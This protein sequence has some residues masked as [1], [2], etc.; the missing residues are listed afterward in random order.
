MASC[1][2]QAAA[3]IACAMG[4]S[5]EPPPL[6]DQTDDVDNTGGGRELDW[7]D[8][9]DRRAGPADPLAQAA[10]AQPAR[11]AGLDRS[12]RRR[13]GTSR[14][15]SLGLVVNVVLRGG[16]GFCGGRWRAMAHYRVRVPHGYALECPS[17][18]S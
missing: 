1:G 17:R 2:A 4:Y 11:T 7:S 14:P 6:P 9:A 16:K 12:G 10:A 15:P 18:S 3:V 5:A 13:G 8:V